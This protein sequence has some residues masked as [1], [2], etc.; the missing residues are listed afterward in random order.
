MKG[1]R[2]QVVL[3][4]DETIVTETPP[5]RAAWAQRGQQV[6]VPV[7]GERAKRVVWG[8]MHIR[9]GRMVLQVTE[10]WNQ[11]GFQALL[12]AIR[13]RWRGWRVVLFVD[14]GSPHRAHRSRAL[15]RR[16]RMDLRFLPTACPH[17]NPIESLWRWGKN[18]LLANCAMP[19]DAAADMFCRGI[20]ELSPTQRLKT[21]GVFSEKFW[22]RKLIL[23]PNLC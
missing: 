16:L 20:L 15:A 8:A 13:R 12:R 18:R 4:E 22:L 2:R 10:R 9:T 19:I 7:T 21:A 6:R 17:L 23:S 14:R 3:F 5:L 11:E 1:R